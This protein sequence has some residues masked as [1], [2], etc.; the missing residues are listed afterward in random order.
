MKEFTSFV[1]AT[2]FAT[3]AL[4][5]ESIPINSCNLILDVEGATYILQEDLECGPGPST[6]NA[7]QITAPNVKLNFDGHRIEGLPGVFNGVLVLADGARISGGTIAGFQTG[8][9]VNIPGR[10]SDGSAITG[11]TIQNNSENGIT[12]IGSSDNQVTDN[13]VSGNSDFGIVAFNRSNNN[14]IAGNTS[15]NNGE[16]GIN[17]DSSNE[18]QVNGN[19]VSN[20]AAGGILLVNSFVSDA[21]ETLHNIVRGNTVYD[22]TIGVFSLEF[23]GLEPFPERN[24]IQG[25]MVGGSTLVD[26]WEASPDCANTWKGNSFGTSSG[27]VACFR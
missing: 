18:N 4:S 7:F 2:L 16:W 6:L 11:M 13:I 10:T 9:I 20:N 27:P 12:L 22:N 14:L 3:S 8:I 15:T 17:I 23:G 5:A 26:L 1:I 21:T 24:V 25:N 19:H